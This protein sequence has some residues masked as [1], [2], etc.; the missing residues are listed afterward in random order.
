MALP[1]ELAA[2]R[3]ATHGLSATAA[4]MLVDATIARC[5]ASGEHFA[6]PELLR[7]KAT[8]LR[9]A[10]GDLPGGEQVL[11]EARRLAQRQG[12]QAWL[13]LIETDRAAR[14]SI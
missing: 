11:D 12:A 1:I 10:D 2:V 4:Q 7:L 5:E 3:V 13:S 8:I 6:Y 14:A 9:H